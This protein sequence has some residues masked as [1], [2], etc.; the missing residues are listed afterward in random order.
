MPVVL[1][2]IQ[3][4]VPQTYGAADAAETF[5]RPWT[6]AIFKSPV[7]GR[8]AITSRGVAG[9]GQADQENHGGA[10]KAVLA[11]AA[12]HYPLWHAELDRGDM[13]PGGFGEELKISGLDET[14]VCIGDTLAIGDVR[15]QVS[16]PRQPC[17]KLARRWRIKDLPA[18]VIDNSRSGWYLRVVTPGEIEPG[19]AVEIVARIHP[20]WTVARASQ[21]MV[22]RH[23]AEADTAELASL[24]E[25]STAWRRELSGRVGKE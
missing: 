7:S 13:S 21:V 1:L 18:R 3:V 25:L 19:Q 2:S 20:A 8:V 10:D 11:Y 16:Q 14:R 17:W 9:D 12:E 6:S 23:G 5:D 4:G 22:R 24:A 15:L